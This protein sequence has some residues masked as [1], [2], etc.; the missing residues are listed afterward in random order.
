MTSSVFSFKSFNLPKEKKKP[1]KVPLGTFKGTSNKDKQHL[2]WNHSTKSPAQWAHQRIMCN[3]VTRVTHNTHEPACVFVSPTVV[4]L[5][6]TSVSSFCLWVRLFRFLSHPLTLSLLTTHLAVWRWV[7]L[8]TTCTCVQSCAR[9]CWAHRTDIYR[10]FCER[11][12]CCSSCT[13]GDARRPKRIYQDER[14]IVW[15]VLKK[16]KMLLPELSVAGEPH[17]LFS[18]LQFWK[19]WGGK[20]FQS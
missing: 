20:Y 12:S 18:S 19:N 15:I 1:L 16:K 11:Y 10:R 9:L 4:F 3:R 14:E 17:V 5:L 2:C 6:T 8:N 13:D 7:T